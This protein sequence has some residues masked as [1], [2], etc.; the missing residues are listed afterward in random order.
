M[1]PAHFGFYLFVPQMQHVALTTATIVQGPSFLVNGV[2]MPLTTFGD[3]ITG[4]LA[5]A[6]SNL[7]ASISDAGAKFADTIDWV[8]DPDYGKKKKPAV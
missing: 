1:V 2:V 4:A 6:G 5:S 7:M 8:I 3:S